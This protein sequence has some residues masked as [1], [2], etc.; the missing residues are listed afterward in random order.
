ME[1][2]CEVLMA[3]GLYKSLIYLDHQESGV[4]YRWEGLESN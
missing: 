2:N 3:I 4:K 1:L